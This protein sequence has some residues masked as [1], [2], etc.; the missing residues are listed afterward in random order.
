MSE[1]TPIKGRSSS[2]RKRIHPAVVCTWAA[3]ISLLATAVI[4]HLFFRFP[5][6]EYMPFRYQHMWA[7]TEGLWKPL[8]SLERV[9]DGVFSLELRGRLNP[10]YWAPVVNAL[11]AVPTACIVVFIWKRSHEPSRGTRAATDLR[12][13]SKQVEKVREDFPAAVHETPHPMFHNI[14]TIEEAREKVLGSAYFQD[15]PSAYDVENQ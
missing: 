14:A 6:P 11:F 3:L 8:R 13:V 1:N 10:Y 7:I 15:K 5:G 9:L 4:P 12:S 2:V